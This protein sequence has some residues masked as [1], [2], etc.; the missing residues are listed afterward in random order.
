M[1]RITLLTII[2]ACFLSA[3][4][5]VAM[6]SINSEI[7]TYQSKSTS[8]QDIEDNK[9]KVKAFTKEIFIDDQSQGASLALEA[10]VFSITDGDSSYTETNTLLIKPEALAPLKT[11]LLKK[12]ALTFGELDKTTSIDLDGS[13]LVDIK[14][15]VWKGEHILFISAYNIPIFTFQTADILELIRIIDETQELNNSEVN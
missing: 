7:Y 3:C 11:I 15:F 8:I 9:I 4:Q 13:G 1:K 5:M 6:Q 12:M 14:A 2:S 10:E